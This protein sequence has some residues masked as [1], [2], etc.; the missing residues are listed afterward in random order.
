M[1]CCLL[2]DRVPQN[3]DIAG[4]GGGGR[5]EDLPVVAGTY[6]SYLSLCTEYPYVGGTESPGA[7]EGLWMARTIMRLAG[8]RTVTL[9]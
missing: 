9:L 3:K 8:P 7:D 1:Y 2:Y 5:V 4:P 6:R